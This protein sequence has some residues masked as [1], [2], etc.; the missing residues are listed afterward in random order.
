[1]EPLLWLDKLNEPFTD[2]NEI[3]NLLQ[4]VAASFC[5]CLGESELANEEVAVVN[6]RGQAEV[7]V[8]LV[9]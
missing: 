9:G 2:L 5:P 8:M 4:L 3:A 7:Q 6:L 1:M